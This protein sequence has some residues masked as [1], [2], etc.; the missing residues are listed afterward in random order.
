MHSE[1]ERILISGTDYDYSRSTA[2]DS[3]LHYLASIHK[4]AVFKNTENIEMVTIILK[5][6][7]THDLRSCVKIQ[8]QAEIVMEQ[9]N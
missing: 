9:Q 5:C 7:A 6:I 2:I 1:K 8:Y 4:V 3:G